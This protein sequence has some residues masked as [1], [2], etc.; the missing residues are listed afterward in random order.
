MVGRLHALAALLSVLSVTTALAGAP[1]KGVGVSLGKIPGGGVAN[2]RLADDGGFSFGIVPAGT[3]RLK[4][5]STDAGSQL[6]S[7]HL[8]VHG[9]RKPIDQ[10][11]AVSNA[12]TARKSGSVIF[13][14]D[15]VSDGKTPIT[16]SIEG[17]GTDGATATPA[18]S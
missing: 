4:L 7:I 8:L 12:A 9:T 15:I 14:V 11:I 18:N 13:T 16:G 3:Y 1:L 17:L 2:A 5:D 10:T 6:P